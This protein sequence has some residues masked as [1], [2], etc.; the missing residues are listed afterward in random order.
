MNGKEFY[1]LSSVHYDLERCVYVWH[2][3]LR[4]TEASQYACAAKGMDADFSKF[5]RVP[6]SGLQFPRQSQK[7]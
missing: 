6:I 2:I 1:R 3:A 4:G 5:Q 7:G